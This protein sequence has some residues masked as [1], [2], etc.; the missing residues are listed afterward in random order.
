MYMILDRQGGHDDILGIRNVHVNPRLNLF[1]YHILPNSNAW[2]NKYIP[3]LLHWSITMDF[4]DNCRI[5]A[6]NACKNLEID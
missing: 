2:S 6:E 1:S 5:D 4:H 3:P